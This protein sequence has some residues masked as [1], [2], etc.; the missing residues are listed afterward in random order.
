[1]RESVAACLT[2]GERPQQWP[3]ER[4]LTEDGPM[5]WYWGSLT[6]VEDQVSPPLLP[7]VLPYTRHQAGGEIRQSV[8]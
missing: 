2:A 3:E 5:D 1:M 4:G 7:H 6:A 8:Q